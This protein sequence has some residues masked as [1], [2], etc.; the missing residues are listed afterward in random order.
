LY[1]G[2]F[3]DNLRHARLDYSRMVLKATGPWPS[4]KQAQMDVVQ[5]GVGYLTERTRGWWY[6]AVD[7]K[8]ALHELGIDPGNTDPAEVLSQAL[9]PDLRSQYYGIVPEDARIGWPKE[10][11]S[12]PRYEWAFVYSFAAERAVPFRKKLAA[13][14]A[15]RR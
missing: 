6:G 11:M 9:P 10:G 2:D 8:Q 14:V 4:S 7:A 13:E 5:V 1:A 12:I 3:T 15:A